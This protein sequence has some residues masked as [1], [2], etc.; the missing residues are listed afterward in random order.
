MHSGLPASAISRPRLGTK[1]PNLALQ[2]TGLS[3]AYGSL[4]RPQLNAGTLGG[5]TMTDTRDGDESRQLSWDQ[6]PG[7]PDYAP[8]EVEAALASLSKAHDR[9]SANDAYNRV[10]FAVGNNHRGT[11]YPRQRRRPE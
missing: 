9:R 11:L 10:L 6:F 3:L 1:S 5:R 2:L 8:R 4:W 7:P